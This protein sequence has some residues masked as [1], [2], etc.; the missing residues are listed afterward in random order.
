[1][2]YR[3]DLNLSY[4]ELKEYYRCWDLIVVGGGIVGLS[5]AVSFEKMFPRAKILILE[6]GILPSGA[7]TK[8]AGFACF[9]T[10][11]EILDDL[12]L[13]PE[14]AVWQ[15]VK[16]RWQGLRMLKERIGIRKLGYEELGGFE[17]FFHEG[18]FEQVVSK[19]DALN[20]R[21]KTELG[22][23]RCFVVEDHRNTPFSGLK[24]MIGNRFEGQIDTGKMMT[25]LQSLCASKGVTMLNGVLVESFEDAGQKVILGTSAGTFESKRLVVATNG[26]ARRLLGIPGVE[27]ARAQILVTS[28]VQNLDIQGTY[29]FDRGYYYFRNVDSRILLGGGRNLAL[30]DEKT[31]DNSLNINIQNALERVLT[32]KILAG[33]KFSV[34]HRWTGIMGVGDEKKPIINAVGNRVVAAVRMGGMGI[35]I[36]SWVGREAAGIASKI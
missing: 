32:E 23:S 31:E 34:E 36:G 30:E 22:L 25:A 28:E 4:W 29:H 24:A 17:L 18:E 6:R 11:G 9:G 14:E 20:K 8:N 27:P 7:S 19:L 26:F 13:M 2:N 35:A 16:M 1:M 10:A 12:S 5:T 21:V 3:K 15:T 33:R